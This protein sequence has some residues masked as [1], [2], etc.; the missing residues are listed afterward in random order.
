MYTEHE[1][2]GHLLMERLLCS[3]N[4]CEKIKW[5]SFLVLELFLLVYHDVKLYPSLINPS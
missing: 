5:D 2:L 4:H 3:S 1:A